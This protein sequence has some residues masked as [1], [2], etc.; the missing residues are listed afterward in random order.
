MERRNRQPKFNYRTGK[1]KKSKSW[2][3]R[4][5]KFGEGRKKH[6][7][8]VLQGKSMYHRSDRKDDK[9]DPSSKDKPK[10]KPEK[11]KKLTY[12]VSKEDQYKA[13]QES[14][15]PKQR[16]ATEAGAKRE[17]IIPVKTVKT[18]GGDYGVY[19]KKSRTAQ[20]FR[21]AFRDARKS[22][23]KI[24][25]WKGKKYSSALAKKKKKVMKIN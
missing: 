15:F 17:G 3:D 1:R 14:K 9:F 12:P 20:S 18:K 25:E 21:D 8:D 16:K 11:K 2:M 10:P 6:F 24:F 23:A 7:E 19:A 13:G 22:G 4:V 5:K